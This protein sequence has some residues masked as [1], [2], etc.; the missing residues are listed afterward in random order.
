MGGITFHF[1]FN[2]CK[3]VTRK[4]SQSNFPSI[5]ILQMTKVG[6]D[7]CERV[8]CYLWLGLGNGFEESAFAG[9]GEP[10]KADICKKFKLK[11]NKTL[12]TFD[13]D[14]VVGWA[15]TLASDCCNDLLR[16]LFLHIIF[17]SSNS[18]L[19]KLP[20]NWNTVLISI[21]DTQIRI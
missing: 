2:Q 11:T 3:F 14:P 17:L 5:R 7:S 15:S 6:F 4:I 19:F 9:V 21:P 16:K 13:T 20:R 18:T 12:L 10:D 8:A 1:I